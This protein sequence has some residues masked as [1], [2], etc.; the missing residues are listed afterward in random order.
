VRTAA[1]SSTACKS[2]HRCQQ[3]GEPFEAVKP[4]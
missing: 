4:L 3:C 1:F 2:L